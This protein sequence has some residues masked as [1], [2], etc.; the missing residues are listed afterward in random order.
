MKQVRLAEMGCLLRKGEASL[1]EPLPYDVDPACHRTDHAF[2]S[3]VSPTV[4]LS[5]MF[6][7]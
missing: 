7:E 3:V 4:Q 5:L 1:E 6:Q 2:F